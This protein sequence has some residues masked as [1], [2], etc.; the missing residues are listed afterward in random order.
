MI[1][2][3]TLELTNCWIENGQS[4]DVP[5]ILIRNRMMSKLTILGGMFY[6]D[7]SSNIYSDLNP[8][9]DQ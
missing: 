5:N 3:P 9:A 6:T 2:S 4:G 1:L 8:C 7:Q